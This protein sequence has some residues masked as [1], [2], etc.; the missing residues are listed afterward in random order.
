MEGQRMKV[1]LQGVLRRTFRTNRKQ[2][3]A[4]YRNKDNEELHHAFHPLLSVW[5][6]EEG[7]DGWDTQYTR[8]N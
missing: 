4:G 7:R 5:S 8:Q 2:G 1:Y 3:R 6:T